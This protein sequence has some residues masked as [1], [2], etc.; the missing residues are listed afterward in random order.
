MRCIPDRSCSPGGSPSGSTVTHVS[1]E[2]HI[3][4][5]KYFVVR[6]CAAVIQLQYDRISYNLQSTFSVG[7]G[8][9]VYP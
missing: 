3:L 1:Y 7:V 4:D 2:S 6:Q 9:A 5:Q 8:L